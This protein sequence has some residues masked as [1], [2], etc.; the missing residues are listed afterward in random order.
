MM[1]RARA[2]LVLGALTMSCSSWFGPAKQVEPSQE[3]ALLP[4]RVRRLSN[5]EYERSASELLGAPLEVANRLPPD[6]RQSGYTHNAEQVV[7]SEM[8]A[9]LDLIT[10]PL[11]HDAAAQRSAVLAPCGNTASSSCAAQVVA[12]LGERA[13]RRPL[14]EDEGR[15]LLAAFS[16]GSAEGG[17]FSGGLELLLRVLLVSPSFLYTTELGPG[18]ARGDIVTLTAYEIASELSYTVRGGPP[19]AELLAAAR[20]GA[21]LSANERARQ[22]RRLIAESDT[23]EQFRQFALEWLEVDGLEQTAKS[24]SV[25]ADYDDLKPHMLDET[26][27]FVDQVMVHHGASVQALLTAGFASVDP[28]MARFYG[29]H[30]YGPEASLAGSGR[31]GVLQQASFLAA[32][33]HEDSSSPVKRGDFVLRRLLC[34]PVKRPGEVG[35]DIVL[36]APTATHTTRDRFDAHT[37]NAACSSCHLQLDQLGFSF[38]NFDGAGQLRSR[39]NGQPV[40]TSAEIWKNGSSHRFADSRALSR[41]LA[42]EPAVSECFARQAFR[43]FT[44]ATRPGAEQAFV[45]LA[46]DLPSDASSNLLEELLAFV[47]SDL[48]VKRAVQR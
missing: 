9:R 21:L 11:A 41:Y 43:Y 17:G 13:F 6:V 42:G 30:G 34:E 24:S 19:D 2:C 22:A 1:S 3:P 31:F 15:T 23:R 14:R 4:A 40:T 8:L 16:A 36:P 48:F 46:R 7:S 33:A 28:D 18:G 10:R 5:L 32:H 45:T 12:T 38:E 20:T 35:I 37:S 25:L 47:S 29:L 27:A 26:R 44:G 39:E